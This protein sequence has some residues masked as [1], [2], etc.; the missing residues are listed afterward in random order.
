MPPGT[1]PGH[2]WFIDGGDATTISKWG[3]YRYFL[4]VMSDAA[5]CCT[6]VYYMRDNSARSFAKCTEIPSS[7]HKR[8]AQRY[9][10]EISVWGLLFHS[11]M[12][13]NV[14][15]ALRA[16]LGVEIEVFPPHCHWLNPY[17]E[18]MIR[19]LKRGTHIRLRYLLG[20]IIDGSV[21]ADASG[22]WPLSMEH[23]AHKTITCYSAITH[24]HNLHRNLCHQG[25]T[26]SSGL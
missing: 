14:F 22:W 1:K 21:V 26:L 13:Q 10:S 16:D 17:A 7:P 2:K 23:G 6:V 20:K 8:N 11:H 19:I 15:G 12:D 18:N 4:L 9:A 24:N 3:G 5:S 25:S